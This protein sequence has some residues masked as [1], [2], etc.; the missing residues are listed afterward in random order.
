MTTTVHDVAASVLSKTG[1]ISTMKLQKLVYYAQAW[2]L[3]ITG[4]TLFAEDFQAWAN[5]PVCQPLFERHRG[6]FAVSNWKDGD[7]TK[8]NEL[9]D[10]VITLVINNY[11]RLSAAPLSDL[12]HSEAPWRQARE[13]LPDD[14]YSVAV[15]ATDSMRDYYRKIGGT[16]ELVGDLLDA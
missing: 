6:V 14:A 13:G 9:Q 15:I 16:K 12:T 2:K 3:A 7:T 4:S 5:G 11:A 1:R 10:A 8:I